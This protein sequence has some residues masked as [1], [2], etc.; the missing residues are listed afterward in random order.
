VAYQGPERQKQSMNKYQLRRIGVASNAAATRP[1]LSTCIELVLDQSDALVSDIL[2]ALKAPVLKPVKVDERDDVDPAIRHAVH[3]LLDE[4]VLVRS[5][6]G[7]A[8]R[9]LVYHSG[10]QDFG[11]APM[12]RIEDI[13]VFDIQSLDAHIEQAL[14]RREVSRSVDSVLPL[15]N[16]QI[17][18]LL[19][20]TSVQPGMNPLKPE[21]FVRALQEMLGV[22]VQDE[23][24]RSAL[25]RPAAIALGSGMAQL[26]RETCDWLRSQGVVPV[27]RVAERPVRAGARAKSAETELDRTL[28]ILDK[29]RALMGVESLPG[30]GGQDFIQ[31]LPSA[32]VALQD[33]RL[34]ESMFQ[35]LKRVAIPALSARAGS[36][37]AGTGGEPVLAA[38]R[39]RQIGRQLGEE[40]VRLLFDQLGH[41]ERIPVPV[42]LQLRALE[43]LLL[44]LADADP[45]YFLDVAH[46]ARVFM[47]RAVQSSVSLA[48][49]DQD[50]VQAFAACVAN[51]V[52]A[53]LRSPVEA[54]S[55]SRAWELVERSWGDFETSR[56]QQRE[57]AQRQRE[58]D[59]KRTVLAQRFA[60]ALMERFR[61]SAMPALVG[62][63][64]RG[65]WAKVLAETSLREDAHD[66]DPKGYLALVDDLVWSVRRPSD[67]RDYTRLVKLIPRLL[68]RVNEGLVLIRYPQESVSL[69]LDEINALHVRALED[70]RS[71]I[72]AA[73]AAQLARQLAEG[74]VHGAV[75]QSPPTQQAE[76]ELPPP[77]SSLETDSVLDSLSP[78]ES[79]VF[80]TGE[81]ADLLL[82]GV[83]VRA[84]LTWISPNRSLF[85]FV[86]GAGL[87]HAMTR[88]MI[89]RLQTQGR[90]RLG[91]SPPEFDLQLDS[92]HGLLTPTEDSTGD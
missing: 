73:R 62:E 13:H 36:D 72:S 34:E 23:A 19:G 39:K 84:R 60:D 37:A 56:Q 26:Y 80:E 51:A 65:P 83:W 81:W 68:A 70:H 31:T 6:F 47:D 92:V 43:P 46:P 11:E 4:V 7:D 79:T 50:G 25:L 35:R 61:S 16:A 48:R 29:L 87:A 66:P 28:A 91:F 90:L 30:A 49:D 40:V 54:A 32:L 21:A 17:S 38:A 74:S 2:E 77:D 20:W 75:A 41:D 59:E 88:R 69:F 63:F 57:A 10:L 45:R 44:R 9:R 1:S 3:E 27:G 53:V 64:L 33:M 58:H 18:A 15:F 86:S 42:R 76:Q 5:A 82:G 52:S 12:S 14:A 8:L 24:V 67:G 89:D 22:C 85:M 71:A 78:S 55:F